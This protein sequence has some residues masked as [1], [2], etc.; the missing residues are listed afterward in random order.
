MK[1]PNYDKLADILMKAGLPYTI[2]IDEGERALMTVGP[3]PVGPRPE[4][5]IA[6]PEERREH[7]NTF[8]HIITE[9]WIEEQADK[10]RR[11]DERN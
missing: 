6:T 8:N 1:K 7:Q 5:R 10:E 9:W 11:H 4:P 2:Q 3:F